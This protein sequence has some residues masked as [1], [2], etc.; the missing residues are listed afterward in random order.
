M[1]MIS[2]RLVPPG[3]RRPG[4]I[5]VTVPSRGRAKKLAASLLSLRDTA[6]RPD[7][8]E[9]LV[10]HDPDD[11]DTGIT[12][13]QLAAD[14]IWEAPERYGFAR[15][16]WYYAALLEQARGEWLLPTWGDDALMTTPGWDDRLRAAPPGTVAYLDGNWPGETCFP[17]VHA[18]ALGAIGRLPLLPAL[19]SWFEHAGRQAGVLVTPG[20]YVLQDR[21]DLTGCPPD[22]THLE[23]G[24]AW[25]ETHWGHDQP[26]YREPWVSLRAGDA[27]ALERLHRAEADYQDRLDG[28]WSDMRSQ[29][30]LLRDAARQHWQPVIAELGVRDCNSTVAFLAGAAA[31]G[32]QVWSVDLNPPAGP[33]P[34]AGGSAWHFLHADD[35]S[36]QAG[37]WLPD[38]LDVLFIDTSHLFDHTLWELREYVPRVRPG[39]RVLCHDTSISAE[40]MVSYGERAAADGPQYP[41]AAALD[42]Y[43]AETGLTWTAQ[44]HVEQEGGKPFSGLGM[45]IIPDGES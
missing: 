30:P 17:A 15:Q 33:F 44:P 4:L 41:V 18:D 28:P 12:A 16:S 10:A 21:P 34:V 38:Q 36:T 31:C 39:G 29:L 26:Y 32:G 40:F 8:V 43:C 2:L 22:Q 45:I 23:G 13:F 19:D 9:I 3:Q 25:R 35:T 1:E 6:A 5:S 11:L 27:A 37:D 7:L 24:G 42:I 14:V 20:I